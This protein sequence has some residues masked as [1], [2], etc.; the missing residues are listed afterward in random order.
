MIWEKKKIAL[1]LKGEVS[2]VI[3]IFGHSF[4]I[5]YYSPDY[6]HGVWFG[7]CVREREREK[8]I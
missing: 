8:E 1:C 6:G 7:V 2:F 5:I 4:V 3:I